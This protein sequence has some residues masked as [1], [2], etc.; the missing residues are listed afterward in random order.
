M[1]GLHSVMNDVPLRRAVQVLTSLV[2]F[3][4]VNNVGLFEMDHMW[5]E[6]V[7]EA[8]FWDQTFLQLR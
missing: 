5:N 1:C 3:L 4:H 6:T 2:W 8:H 7:S